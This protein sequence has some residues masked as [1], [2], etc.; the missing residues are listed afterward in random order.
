MLSDLVILILENQG[1]NQNKL[2]I[3][4]MVF[5]WCLSPVVSPLVFLQG[6]FLSISET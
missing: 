1:T 4:Y 5:L 6:F 2:L 3:E